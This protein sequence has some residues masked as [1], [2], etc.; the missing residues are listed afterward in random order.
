MLT[1]ADSRTML[2]Q[3]RTADNVKSVLDSWTMQISAGQLDNV[4][5]VKPDS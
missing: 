3:C 4:K 1:S 5:S 2:N